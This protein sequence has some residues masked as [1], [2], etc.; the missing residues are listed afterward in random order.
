MHR[1]S[2]RAT[3][4]TVRYIKP[5]LCVKENKFLCLFYFTRQGFTYYVNIESINSGIRLF[6]SPSIKC[7]NLLSA[8]I[9]PLTLLAFILYITLLN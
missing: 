8:E 3:E 2:V 6:S 5:S 9:W 7:R 4:H 1:V